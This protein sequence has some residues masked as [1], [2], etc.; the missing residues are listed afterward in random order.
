MKIDE[1]RRKV[2]RTFRNNSTTILTGLGVSGTITTAVLAARA[3]AAA[4]RVLSEE[5]PHLDKKEKAKLTWKLYIPAA[6]SGSLTIACIIGSQRMGMKKTAAA[7]SLLTVSERAFTEYKDKVVEQL[8]VKKEQAIRD[9]IAQDR[10]NANPAGSQVIIGGAGEVLCYEHYTGRYFH[11]DM[12]TMRRAEN[13]IN[14]KMLRED[15]ASLHDLYYMLGLPK[16]SHSSDQGWKSD[17]LMKLEFST[18]L[19]DD[20]RPC[21]SF[22]YNYVVAL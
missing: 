17:R 8:G 2:E 3:G 18:V 13:E 19:S 7:Y 10:V 9:E 6:V 11:S 5:S 12:E 4:Q 22:E 15:E 21:L 20:G 1:L 14:A 16:T